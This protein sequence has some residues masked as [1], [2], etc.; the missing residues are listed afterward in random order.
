MA[1]FKC[2]DSEAGPDDWCEYDAHDPE[3]AAEMH[4]V[5][6]DHDSGGEWFQDPTR[7]TMTVHVRYGEGSRWTFE[8]SFD[9]SKD[10]YSRD[11]THEQETV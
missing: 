3:E 2:R 6:M 8:I 1:M 9:Y 11:I 4:A 7:D 5:A 10:F